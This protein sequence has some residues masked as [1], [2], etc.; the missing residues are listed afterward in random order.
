M[1]YLDRLLLPGGSR[2]D[3]FHISKGCLFL[4]E[5]KR[6]NPEPALAT[7]TPVAV[8]QAIA[9]LK[10]AKYVA[11]LCLLQ[12]LTLFFQSRGSSFLSG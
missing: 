3:T 5:A 4:V 2:E 6:Q 9:L 12:H 10:T 8:S 1:S 11:V 7:Y